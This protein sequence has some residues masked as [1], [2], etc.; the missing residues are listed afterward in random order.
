MIW[1]SSK[2][3]YLFPVLRIRRIVDCIQILN[4]VRGHDTDLDSDLDPDTGP[5]KKVQIRIP[6]TA[7][8]FAELGACSL[9]CVPGFL[10]SRRFRNA[11][12]GMQIFLKNVGTQNTKK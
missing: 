11:L 10:H 5:Q 12:A 6:N 4:Q 8:S 2:K 1:H 7:Y 3:L 9:I